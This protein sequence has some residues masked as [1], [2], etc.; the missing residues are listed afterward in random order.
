[1][2]WRFLFTPCPLSEGSPSYGQSHDPETFRTPVHSKRCKAAVQIALAPGVSRQ[3][4]PSILVAL[5]PHY[6]YVSEDVT[7]LF[8][9][10]EELQSI[11]NRQVKTAFDGP[12]G[13]NIIPR[14]DK[15]PGDASGSDGELSK[16]PSTKEAIPRLAQLRHPSQDCEPKNICIRRNLNDSCKSVGLC[17][18]DVLYWMKLKGCPARVHVVD[19]NMECLQEC[20]KNVSTLVFPRVAEVAQFC[21]ALC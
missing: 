4:V 21:R 6:S 12:N 2:S 13:I 16:L 20:L 8:S 7:E 14:A 18:F 11:G 19:D 3:L 10:L 9:V 1:M 5:T 17:F 15:L